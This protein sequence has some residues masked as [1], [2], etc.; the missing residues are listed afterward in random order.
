MRHLLMMFNHL[1]RNWWLPFVR[2]RLSDCDRNGSKSGFRTTH[3]TG[4]QTARCIHPYGI[5]Y[6]AGSAADSRRWWSKCWQKFGAREFRWKVWFYIN[7]WLLEVNSPYFSNNLLRFC[8][9]SEIFCPAVLESLPEDL[10]YC[11]WFKAKLVNFY[12]SCLIKKLLD[13]F[14]EI[15]VFQSTANFC[16]V[17]AN[18]STIS[19]RSAEKLKLKPIDLP[20]RIK[21]FP[22]SP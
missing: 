7:S 16:I 20:G 22:A 8:L 5:S 11:S 21:E 12:S 1:N 19:K 15:P 14:N 6:A 4:E 13:L 9:F 10:L 18:N 17:E 2:I 3:T